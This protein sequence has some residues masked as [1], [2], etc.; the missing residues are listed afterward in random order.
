MSREIKFKALDIHETKTKGE[1]MK[2]YFMN[3]EF[4]NRFINK[5]AFFTVRLDLDEVELIDIAK[6]YIRENF[7]D[8]CVDDLTIN[9]KT[10]NKV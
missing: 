4:Y 6:D 9:I 1:S 7:D 3:I 8:L 5:F 2:T 10:F